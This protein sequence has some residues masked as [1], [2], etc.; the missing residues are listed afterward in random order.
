MKF[1]VI[2]L[3]ALF[4]GLDNI[5]SWLL[6]WT[7][8]SEGDSLQVILCVILS[9]AFN[10][11]NLSS[12]MGVF[13]II[14]NVL[15]FWLIDSI[16][17]AKDASTLDADNPDAL[18]RSE[19]E[20]LF[21]TA[22]DEEDVGSSTDLESQYTTARSRSPA[23]LRSPARFNYDKPTSGPGT[24]YEIKSSGSSTPGETLELHAYP[25]SI[26][27]SFPSTSSSTKPNSKRRLKPP[28]PITVH[29]SSQPAVNSPGFHLSIDDA[30]NTEWIDDWRD[31]DRSPR[32][33]HKTAQAG[34]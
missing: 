30:S 9:R 20:P 26:S 28:A 6:S 25:P 2:L 15:Q 31:G 23:R 13:P 7:W 19:Q 33:I 14:M 12:T 3:L 17:K 32:N 18:N 29:S 4:P 21:D 8:T 24:P 5:G 27:H 11:A 16:V 34:L 10:T 1:L 22:Q